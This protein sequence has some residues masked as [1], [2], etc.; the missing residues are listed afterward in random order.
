MSTRIE[1]PYDRQFTDSDVEALVARGTA[2]VNVMAQLGAAYQTLPGY[3]MAGYESEVNAL[4]ADAAA[5]NVHLNA[6]RT[7]LVGM[8]A[9]CGPL[10]DK[11]IGSLRALSGLLST[12]AQQALL[13]QITGPTSQGGGSPTPPPTP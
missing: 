1:V 3:A 4:E 10:H 7:L 6:I 12:D 2:T 9:K 13:T 8:D 5:I 11:N